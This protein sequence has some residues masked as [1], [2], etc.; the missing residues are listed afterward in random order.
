MNNIMSNNNTLKNM[1]WR[2]AERCGAQGVSFI[3]SI[4]LARLL[5]PEMYGTIALVTV[6]TAILQVFIDSGMGSALIQKKDADDLDF[7]TVFYFNFAVCVILYIVMFSAAPAITSFYND[8][9]LT[10]IIR[11]LSF[12]LVIS[13]VRNVQQAFVSRHMLFKRFFFST[14]GGTIGAAI[15]GITMAYLGF[16]VWALVAQQMFNAI[17]DTAILWITVKWRPKWCFSFK[18]LKDLF[19]FGWKLLVSA[20]IDVGY[21]NL[22]QLIIGKMYSSKDLAFYNK[23]QQFPNLAITNLN[24]S[25]DSVLFPTM[26]SAQ[27]DK[28]KVKA[29]A[30]KSIQ[31]SSYIIWPVMVGLAVCAEP[32]IRLILTEKWLPCVP[33]MQ[34]FCIT[35][36]F[37]PIHT[38]N[39]NAIKAVGRSDIFL[40]LEII[41]KIIGV[42]TIL[43]TMPFGVMWIAIG[44]TLTGPISVLIN[45]F[46]NRK[47][48]NYSY[49]E[50]ISD[51]IPSMIISTVMGV[52]V[53]LIIFLNFNLAITLLI[54]VPVGIIVYL[55][56]SKVFKIKSFEFVVDIIRKFRKKG[57]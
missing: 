16:G 34:L 1:L 50:Q 20:L 46:P 40:K 3:V 38:A 29:M 47:L 13:G 36:A 25:I 53:Y 4:V 26:A 49:R 27:D 9:S 57:V 54:Q 24:T 37:F 39:L 28:E 31:V 30:R 17:V 55:V 7:S 2:F 32:L 12:T 23:G 19:S 56:L 41:K 52:C 18:R 11:V 8:Q 42:I 43:I 33:Y 14:L 35:Y 48:L 51:M 22:R 10:P 6:F 21:N 15:V 44:C 5:A 45:A